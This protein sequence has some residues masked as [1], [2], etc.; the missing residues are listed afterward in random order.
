MLQVVIGLRLQRLRDGDVNDQVEESED[1]D[2][3][4]E[5]LR[6]E[7]HQRAPEHHPDSRYPTPYTV[8]MS[9]GERPSSILS[10]R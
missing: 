6:S 8:W 1:Q 10:R 2:E 9:F 7:A 4:Y 5:V 3:Q